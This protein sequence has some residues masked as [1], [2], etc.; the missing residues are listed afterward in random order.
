[1]IKVDSLFSNENQQYKDYLC[2]VDLLIET[3]TNNGQSN[4][5]VP[6]DLNQY[7]AIKENKKYSDV[8][9]NWDGVSATINLRF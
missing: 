1:M 2:D 3:A 6:A 5:I 7:N 8:D 9:I 4:V